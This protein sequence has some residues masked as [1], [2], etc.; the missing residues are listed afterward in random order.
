[1]RR[2]VLNV[3]YHIDQYTKIISELKAEVERLKHVVAGQER[4]LERPRTA[5]APSAAASRSLHHTQE[6]EE[7]ARAR[8]ME[9]SRELQRVQDYRKEML[10][11]FN[12]R[13]QIR[14]ELI[15]V[16]DVAIQADILV[17][18]QELTISRSVAA[19][20]RVAVRLGPEYLC[21]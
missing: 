19:R 1:M 12:R 10:A 15:D 20:G 17:T 6:D 18:R 16:D 3:A 8:E 5:P 13:M 11:N 9:E 4:Q 7:V 2:N 14:K 21:R